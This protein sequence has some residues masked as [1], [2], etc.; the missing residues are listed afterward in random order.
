[1]TTTRTLDLVC[2][3]RVAVD[4]YGEQLGSAL[5]AMQSFAMYLGGCAGN[6]A[7][8]CARQDLRV[9][10]LSR[11]GDEQM[12]RFVRQTLLAEGV[13][14]SRLQTDPHRLTGLV[15][16]ALRDRATFPL[17]FYRENCADM[18]V[19][20]GDED[21]AFIARATALLVTGTHFSQAGV[22]AVSRQAMAA[23]RAAGTRV[24]LDIDYRPVLWG[25]TGHCMGESRYVSNERVSAHLQS[26]LPGC[27]LVVGTE[28]EFRI[29]GGSD[30][31]LSA[32]RQVRSQTP[33]LLVLKS[34]P[35]GC[36]IFAGE[37]PQDLDHGQV[38]R[39][40]PVEVLNVLGAGDAFLSGFLR[41]WLRDEDLFTCAR[42]ANACGALVV[43]RHGCAPAMPTRVELDDYLGRAASIARIDR[44]PR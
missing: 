1:M 32:L 28:E 21:K 7:V 40:L 15:L 41:G 31:V 2:L 22:D 26:I 6:I 38:E 8:G 33:A 30:D 3:G 37:I 23:A 14:V 35:K 27:D 4:I 16:L 20:C 39:G 13:D 36:V 34:G 43:S 44:D 5:E 9:A 11:V 29:A 18:A 19:E 42:Y 12:G 24:V 25:L 10:M 17:V